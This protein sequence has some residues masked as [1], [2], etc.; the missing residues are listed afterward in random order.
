MTTIEDFFIREY[1]RMQRRVKELEAEVARLA[2]G[3]YGCFDLHEKRE[4]VN[5][6]PSASYYYREEYIA[7]DDLKEAVGMDD[8]R[9]IEW[10]TRK[11]RA[12]Q[13]SYRTFYPISVER[14]VFK[15]SLRFIETDRDAV[16]F[17][18]GECGLET[19]DFDGESPEDGLG[20][21]V[22]AE[23]FDALLKAALPFVRRNIEDEIA[24][25]DGSD[26]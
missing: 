19:L 7:P 14:K 8:A 11:H 5:V 23:H 17:T 16:L 12:S 25:R 2:P 26:V 18:D 22:G 20:N 13:G 21:W 4:A 9:L 1:E 6:T 3:G 24:R 10:A 15:Y